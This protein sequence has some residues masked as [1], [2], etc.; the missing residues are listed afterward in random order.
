MTWWQTGSGNSMGFGIIRTRPGGHTKRRTINVRIRELSTPHL[1]SIASSQKE[2]PAQDLRLVSRLYDVSP[3]YVLDLNV[4]FDLLKKRANAH[5]PCELQQCDSARNHGRVCP[6]TGTDLSARTDGPYPRIGK[7]APAPQ[8]ATPRSFDRD[9]YH[10]R[11][12]AFPIC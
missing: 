4:L 5:R 1:F 11:S 8:G 12:G 6:R 10:A 7:K 9:Y 3:I 2:Q